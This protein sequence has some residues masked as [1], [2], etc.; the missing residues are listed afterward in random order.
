MTVRDLQTAEIVD[1]EPE[2]TGAEAD[3]QEKLTQ[4]AW[5]IRRF[6]SLGGALCHTA[7]MTAF[8][9]IRV[10]GHFETWPVRSTAFRL[11]LQHEFYAAHRKPP[12]NDA[13]QGAI[14]TLKA[15]ARFDSPERHVALRV[16]EH[17][18]RLY[19]DLTD[20][21]WRAVEIGPDTWRL[22]ADA[23]VWFRRAPGVLPL[24]VPE[25]GGTVD[26]LRPFVNV[27]SEDDFRLIVAWLV[28]ALI[29]GTP[30]P[31]LI[32]QGGQGTA[33]STTAKL[34]R[35]LIDPSEAPFRSPPKDERDLAIAARNAHVVAFDNLSG[36]PD[37]LS[38]ALCKVSTGGAFATR[39]LYSD[40]EEELF[41]FLR[42]VIVNGIDCIAT[43]P[44]LID[45]A[46][47][48][49][50]PKI[51][52]ERKRP[53][54]DFLAEFEAISPLVLGA[55]L[56]AVAAALGRRHEVKL[57]RLPRMADFALWL[58]AAEPALGWPHGTFLAAYLA[59]RK[60]A[61]V[62]GLEAD[63]VA[64][65]LRALLAREPEWHGTP[66]A[67]LEALS[68]EVPES[69]RRMRAWP[70]AAQSLSNRLK[71]LAPA[72]E[73]AGIEATSSKDHG[74]RYWSIRQKDEN[75]R[76]PRVP[77]SPETAPLLELDGD[78]REIGIVPLAS[79]ASPDGSSLASPKPYVASPAS[80]DRPP[81]EAA[82][83][84]D[85]GQMGDAG[86]ARFATHLA[87]HEIEDD[88]ELT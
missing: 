9:R 15:K 78:A 54:R 30:Y 25:R 46:I 65:A 38:D 84:L 7:D 32:L 50:L 26:L 20:P 52:E 10:N 73:A 39:K 44:D 33:K 6:E 17:D 53:E 4:A 61:N 43:R 41:T 62:A 57:D 76:V 60:E 70:K 2:P 48:L 40:D 34:L 71:R 51:P 55:L 12:S 75:S 16:A 72:L 56:D 67:L 37:W 29:P 64:V 42:P 13:C 24:P 8:A 45:R 5:L 22:V 87:D 81:D 35:L 79:P 31:V 63:P 59:N 36:L 49:D 28:Q 69:T 82:S 3:A 47:I 80:P 19:L 23:P 27:A 11:W 58:T 68:G 88:W 74:V 14:D 83:G 66:S 18:G 86:D 21:A 85:Y 77:Q 1:F